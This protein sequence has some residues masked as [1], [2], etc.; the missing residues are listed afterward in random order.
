M[1]DALQYP[2]VLCTCNADCSS[3]LRFVLDTGEELNNRVVEY[4]AR[5]MK[6]GDKKKGGEGAGS[7]RDAEEEG[8]RKGKEDDDEEDYGR[9]TCYTAYM[10]IFDCDLLRAVSLQLFPR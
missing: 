3:C 7:R 10:A 6:G 5:A 8:E 4:V 1:Q 9:G 2:V